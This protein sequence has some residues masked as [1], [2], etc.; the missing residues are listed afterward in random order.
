MFEGHFEICCDSNAVLAS[1]VSKFETFHSIFNLRFKDQSE[2]SPQLDFSSQDQTSTFL[3]PIKTKQNTMGFFNKFLSSWAHNNSNPNLIGP[4]PPFHIN[5]FPSPSHISFLQPNKTHAPQPASGS[6][7]NLYGSHTSPSRRNTFHTHRP[8][9][10]MP[11]FLDHKSYTAPSS[12]IQPT[13]PGLAHSHLTPTNTTTSHYPT[14]ISPTLVTSL[15]TPHSIPSRPEKPPFIYS[16]NVSMVTTPSLV[17][18]S[19]GKGKMKW[20][21]DDDDILLAKLKNPDMR[22]Q[23]LLNLTYYWKLQLILLLNYSMLPLSLALS[24]TLWSN[25]FKGSREGSQASSHN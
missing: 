9:R 16:T 21:E 24:K 12:Q 20:T 15:E 4:P 7:E 1:R 5:Y 23:P 17:S 2:I 18:H 25:L 8:S 3:T 10:C 19:R 13:T 22:T 14:G 6:P 11:Y